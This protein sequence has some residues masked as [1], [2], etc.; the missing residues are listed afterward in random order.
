MVRAEHQEAA[1]ER[2]LTL[3]REEFG[4]DLG[5]RNLADLDAFLRLF[6]FSTVREGEDIVSLTFEDRMML[7]IDD[8]F[9]ELGPFVE[10]GSYILMHSGSGARW[11]YV[12]EDGETTTRDE[13]S[14][15]WYG[16]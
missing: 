14:K 9:A 6:A 7:E 2:M 16:R 1:L 4:Y 15:P 3:S 5:D 11:R 12:F 10:S 13:P 8:V